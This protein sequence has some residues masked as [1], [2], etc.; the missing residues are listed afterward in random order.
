MELDGASSCLN[1]LKDDGSVEGTSV[2]NLEG[3]QEFV[4]RQ[5]NALPK[6]ALFLRMEGSIESH[7]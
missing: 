7:S 5:T 3:M 6:C 2:S 1:A 4:F